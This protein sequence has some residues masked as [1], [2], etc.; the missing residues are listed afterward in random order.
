MK[1]KM[2]FLAFGRKCG[3][4]SCRVLVAESAARAM[5]FDINPESASRPNPLAVE[6]NISRREIGAGRRPGHRQSISER[7]VDIGN[8]NRP[9]G[10]RIR[11]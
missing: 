7:V 10:Q 6:A 9:L 4:G 2:T 1:Q 3:D 11:N 8:S 5:L